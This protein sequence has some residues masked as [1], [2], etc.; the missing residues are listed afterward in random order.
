MD[1]AQ[2]VGAEGHVP[3]TVG[4]GQRP[5]LRAAVFQVAQKRQARVG[6]LGPNLVEA[7]CAD[8]DIRQR[9]SLLLIR[10][11][12]AVLQDCAPGLRGFPQGGFR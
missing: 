6:H 9:K 8:T 1:E 5:R 3:D 7:A 11:Q 4:C 12:D 10:L 2:T